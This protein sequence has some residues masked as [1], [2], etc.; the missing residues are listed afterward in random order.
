MSSIE[1]LFYGNIEPMRLNKETEL[2]IKEKL[3]KLCQQEED[4]RN[5]VASELSELF[6]AYVK[7]YDDFS[8]ACYADSF[9]S[10]FKM[11]SRPT[12]ET[13]FE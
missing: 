6:E 10:G 8:A 7:S 3:E 13:F 11:G 12:Y 9:V 1:D 4:I 5:S 2:S